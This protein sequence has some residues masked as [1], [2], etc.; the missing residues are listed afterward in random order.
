MENHTAVESLPST[1]LYFNVGEIIVREGDK[2]DG[3]FILLQGKVGV[4]KRDLSITEISHP[5]TVIGEIGFLLGI[6]RTA[7][8]IAHEPTVVLHVHITLDELIQNYPQLAKRM[9][10]TL[11]ERLTKTTEDWREVAGT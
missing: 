11:A 2:S 4:F 9:M 6:P 8:L 1:K 3:W 7:T 5:G 10:I